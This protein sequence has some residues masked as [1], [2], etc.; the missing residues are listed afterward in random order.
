MLRLG[1]VEGSSLVSAVLSRF[2][3][4]GVPNPGV[5][6]TDIDGAGNNDGPS[7]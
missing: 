1:D 4:S 2:K 6:P 5:V 3:T 7:H